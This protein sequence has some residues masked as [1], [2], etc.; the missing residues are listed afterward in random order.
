M[1]DKSEMLIAEVERHPILYE[2]VERRGKRRGN[3]SHRVKGVGIAAH[4]V[5]VTG[6]ITAFCMNGGLC[7]PESR[8]GRV[9]GRGRALYKQALTL[10]T[11]A[12]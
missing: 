10:E 5:T 4:I 8:N 7:E 6:G 12:F 2:G 9:R 1:S 11:S 3:F